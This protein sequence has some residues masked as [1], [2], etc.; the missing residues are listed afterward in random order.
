MLSDKTEMPI[1]KTI[2]LSISQDSEKH[3]VLLLGI[4][5]SIAVSPEKPKDCAKKMGAVWQTVDTFYREIE[6]NRN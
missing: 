2:L 5:R 3:A 1:V 4:A 6:K